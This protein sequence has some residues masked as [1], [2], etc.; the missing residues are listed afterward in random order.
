MTLEEA[1]A[2]VLH[3][4]Q[5]LGYPGTG[6]DVTW[7]S[8]VRKMELPRGCLARVRVVTP[9]WFLTRVR[10]R[11]RLRIEKYVEYSGRFYAAQTWLV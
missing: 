4:I 11:E 2:R 7:A 1:R 9:D 3:S 8:W 10:G 5:M 6:Q